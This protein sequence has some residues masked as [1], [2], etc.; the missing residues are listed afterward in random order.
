MC[1]ISRWRISIA[2]TETTKSSYMLHSG[3]RCEFY[4]PP[5]KRMADAPVSPAVV[6]MIREVT[7]K[8]GIYLPNDCAD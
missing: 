6:N 1:K 4:Y 3:S 8:T 2:I 7:K 5:T